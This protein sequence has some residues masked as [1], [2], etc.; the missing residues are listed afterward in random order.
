MNSKLLFR[1]GAAALL[2]AC[3]NGMAAEPAATPGAP[4]QPR[5]DRVAY[6]DS[7]GMRSQILSAQPPLTASVARQTT[8]DTPRAAACHRRSAAAPCSR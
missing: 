2:A 3:V 7:P 6:A 1:A 5:A 8:V 4:Q